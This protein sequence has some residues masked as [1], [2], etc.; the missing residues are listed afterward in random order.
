M[1]K[2]TTIIEFAVLIMSTTVGVILLIYQAR[3]VYV[4]AIAAILVWGVR[5]PRAFGRLKFVGPVPTTRAEDFI[6]SAGLL[7]GVGILIV[8]FVL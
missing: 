6:D 7:I 1:S 3:F 5:L 4:I 2:P 8:N